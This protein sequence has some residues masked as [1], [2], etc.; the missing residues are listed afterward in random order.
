MGTADRKEGRMKAF[1]GCTSPEDVLEAFKLIV[2]QHKGDHEVIHGEMDNLMVA[3]LTDLGY[4]KAMKYY[5]RQ[6][7]WYA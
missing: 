1:T 2:R 5:K 7:R 3:I 6:T 4:E